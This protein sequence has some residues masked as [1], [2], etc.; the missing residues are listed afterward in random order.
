MTIPTRLAKMQK[1]KIS[2]KNKPVFQKSRMLLENIV[3]Y[4]IEYTDLIK[5]I[6]QIC[7]Y[8]FGK[9]TKISY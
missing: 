3:Q 4:C 8:V 9:G 1:L 7:I 2:F 6:G 5:N